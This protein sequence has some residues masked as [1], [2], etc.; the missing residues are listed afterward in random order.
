MTSMVKGQAVLDRLTADARP[1]RSPSLKILGRKTDGKV[2]FLDPPVPNWATV[3]PTAAAILGA[4]DGTRTIRDL[5][6]V[7]GS[8]LTGK[9][10]EAC[11]MAA[12]EHLDELGLLQRDPEPFESPAHRPQLQLASIHLTRSC[13]LRC[14]YCL[15]HAGK[16]L[17]NELSTQEFFSVMDA[18]KALNVEHVQFVGGEPLMRDDAFD[19]A[20]YG[21]SLGLCTTL[22]TNGTLIDPRAAERIRE[23]FEGGVQVS[24]DGFEPENDRMRGRGT[25][26]KVVQ[27]LQLLVAEGIDVSVS[28]TISKVN[29]HSL[30]DFMGFLVELGVPSF[31]ITNLVLFG[32]GKAVRAECLKQVEVDRLLV[33]AWKKWK[34]HIK[35]YQVRDILPPKRTKRLKC[36]AGDGI[37]EIS[38]DGGVYACDR[39]LNLN[40]SSGNIRSTDLA[41][42]YL[43]APHLVEIRNMSVDNHPVCSQCDFRY[44]CAGGCLLDKPAHIDQCDVREAFMWRL[45]ELER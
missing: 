8:G 31:H 30:E 36:G 15:F 34:D 40:M 33:D 43:K 21:K 11:V 44:M 14:R 2:V 3:S 7:F 5:A 26:K 23:V 39:Y 29:A 12:V 27:A 24:L 25:F 42:V 38:S 17:P 18:L 1:K 35:I 41:E 37:I 9:D 4:C 16:P 28:S 6:A 20:A 10:D 19:I 45:T 32:R 13:N 22:I